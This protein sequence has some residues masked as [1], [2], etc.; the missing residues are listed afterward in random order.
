VQAIFGSTLS[1]QEAERLAQSRQREAERQLLQAQKMEA[2]GTLAG[3][4]AHDLNNAL[5]PV[6]AMEKILQKRLPTG[7]QERAQND[8][9]VQ[10]A[11]RAKELVQQVQSQRR[12]GADA[13]PLCRHARSCRY[14]AHLPGVLI[15][16]AAMSWAGGGPFKLQRPKVFGSPLP[17]PRDRFLV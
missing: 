16:L 6:L 5:V 15:F 3:G 4:I 12:P 17:R 10:G 8:L 1:S 7:S 13:R 14:V 11:T 2:L 9:I